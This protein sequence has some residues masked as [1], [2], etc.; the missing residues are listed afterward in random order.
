MLLEK[1]FTLKFK[2]KKK[3]DCMKEKKQCIVL[4]L[5]CRGVVQLLVFWWHHGD[6]D[7][8]SVWV[9]QLVNHDG[10]QNHAKQLSGNTGS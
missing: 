4:W 8:V 10:G 1:Y 7:G 3:Q 2:K 5:V 9:I 6:H